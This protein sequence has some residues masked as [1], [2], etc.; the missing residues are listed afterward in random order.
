MYNLGDMGK[1]F[2]KD[3]ASKGLRT[4]RLPKCDVDIEATLKRL[5]EEEGDTSGKFYQATFVVTKSSIPQVLVG[6]TYT[7]A[8]FQGASKVD[9]EKC[10]RKLTPLIVACAGI[11]P[12]ELDRVPEQTGEFLH[13]SG[14]PGSQDNAGV[15]LDLPF[16]CSRRMGEA[17]PDKETGKVPA[18]FLEKDGTPKRFAQDDYSA[19]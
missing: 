19:A 14:R 6:G 15:D 5:T 2:D 3:K 8:F 9:R 16:R 1:S 7:Q 17:R 18:E 10:W 12:S 11:L 13:L 4:P